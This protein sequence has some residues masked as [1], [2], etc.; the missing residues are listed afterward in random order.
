MSPSPKWELLELLGLGS[1]CLPLSV[2]AAGGWSRRGLPGMG[3]RA[4]GTGPSSLL[5]SK[6]T[7]V[8]LRA[9]VRATSSVPRMR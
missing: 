7:E 9:G 5:S 6:G 3:P 2:P 8:N 4:L 1:R